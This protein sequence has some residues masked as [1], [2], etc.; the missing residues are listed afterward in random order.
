MYRDV[1]AAGPAT[2]LFNHA[3]KRLNCTNSRSTVRHFRHQV[4]IVSWSLSFDA[5]V[6]NI[7]C[8]CDCSFDVWRRYFLRTW[9][10][11]I[12]LYRRRMKGHAI[13]WIFDIMI[14]RL[15]RLRYSSQFWV[16]FDNR[17]LSLFKVLTTTWRDLCVWYLVHVEDIV[18]F[19]YYWRLTVFL[20]GSFVDIVQSVY[21]P[22]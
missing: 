3:L 19:W 16:L 8:L 1:Y 4:F 13:Y 15:S 10:H 6:Q 12:V 22:W 11:F 2:R 7:I 18:L 9:L 21:T 5:F 17:I 20:P 14:T